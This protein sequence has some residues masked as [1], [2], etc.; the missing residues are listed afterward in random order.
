MKKH[1]ENCKNWMNSND[2]TSL[3]MIIII[4][5]SIVYF[6]N[7]T[8]EPLEP[9]KKLV[10]AFKCLLDRAWALSLFTFEPKFR[11]GRAWALS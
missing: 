8:L 2:G 10:Q 3:C 1:M 5:Q 6:L 11:L 4:L 7:E 9:S